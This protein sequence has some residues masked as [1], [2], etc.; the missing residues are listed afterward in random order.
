LRLYLSLKQISERTGVGYLTVKSLAQRRLHKDAGTFPLPDAQIGEVDPDGG[1]RQVTYG[2]LP[3]RVDI[4]AQD[5]AVNK[6]A[7][8]GSTKSKGEAK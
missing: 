5:Y 8:R 1:G 2:W 3:D 4:W 6:P 7:P